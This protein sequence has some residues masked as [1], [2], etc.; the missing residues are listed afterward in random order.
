MWVLRARILSVVD[1]G[2]PNTAGGRVECEETL[3]RLHHRPKTRKQVGWVRGEEE[4]LP[5]GGRNVVSRAS[6]SR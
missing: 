6:G 4:G 5:A 3:H 2:K 1:Q